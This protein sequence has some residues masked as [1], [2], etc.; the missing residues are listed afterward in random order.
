M[1]QNYLF[2]YGSL[3]NPESRKK[4][5]KSGEATPV[6]VMGVQRGWNQVVSHARATVLGAR[7]QAGLT[8]N[9]VIIP[10]EESELATF[11]Q[12]EK[13]GG[14]RRVSLDKSRIIHLESADR[15][16][17]FWMYV[18]ELLELQTP[19]EENPIIQS[20]ADV[21]LTGCFSF[22]ES[23]A[24]EFVLTTVGWDAPWINDRSDPRYPRAMDR[25]P[26]AEAIDSLLAELVPAAFRNRR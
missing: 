15:E 14:Y 24:R 18:A 17:V 16:G 21:A 13:D 26:L 12:R 19:S 22:G 8:C 11:D 2:G 5:G 23:F 9:G 7:E 3:I 20:Y 10:V 6:R 4:T 1:T 25:V